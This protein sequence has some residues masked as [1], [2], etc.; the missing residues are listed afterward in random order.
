MMGYSLGFLCGLF[1]YHTLGV[2][3]A[4]DAIHTYQDYKKFKDVDSLPQIPKEL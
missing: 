4:A 2:V 1:P 3:L